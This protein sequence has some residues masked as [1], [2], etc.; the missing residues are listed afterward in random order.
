[1]DY[2]QSKHPSFKAEFVLN[3]NGETTKRYL[4]IDHCP[5]ETGCRTSVTVYVNKGDLTMTVRRPKERS[6]EIVRTY[7]CI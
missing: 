2:R 6:F 1:M 4:G 5:S 7:F 3:A